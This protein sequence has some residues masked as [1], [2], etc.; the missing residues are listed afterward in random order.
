MDFRRIYFNDK[1]LNCTFTQTKNS[2]F[3][4]EQAFEDFSK[5]GNYLVLEI[6]K[7]NISTWE[8]LENISQKLHI[9]Q[10]EIGYAGLKDKNATTTQ[11]VSIPLKYSNHINKIDSKNITILNSYKHNQKL[12]IGMLKGN[13]FKI[14]LENFKE[15]DLNI[16]YQNLGSIQ[17]HGFPNYFGYQRFGIENDFEKAKAVAYGETFIK[18]KKLQKFLTT[19]YQSYLFNAWLHQRVKISKEQNIKKLI[20]LKG[21]IKDKNNTITGAM[22]GNSVKLSKEEALKLEQQFF[23]PFIN[24]KGFRRAASIDPKNIKNKFLK[25]KNQMILEFFLPKSS[26]ATVLLEALGVKTIK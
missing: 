5:K 24:E 16:F 15:T 12:K 22:C 9:K 3:V 2:F 21:D 4:K 1:K 25:D 26:Y 10:N 20:E 17:K 23:D 7:Q 8:L 18:D 19:A 6:K 14:V 13:H 11:F